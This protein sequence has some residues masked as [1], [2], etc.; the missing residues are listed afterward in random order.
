MQ[1]L[2]G[3]GGQSLHLI[4]RWVGRKLLP[5]QNFRNCFARF[6]GD[7]EEG[8]CNIPVLGWSHVW[9]KLWAEFS[10]PTEFS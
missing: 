9:R 7:F 6:D 8:V 3:R 5:Q 10:A 4:R 1:L 2:G